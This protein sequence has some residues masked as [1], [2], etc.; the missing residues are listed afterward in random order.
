MQEKFW[1]CVCE[2]V[3]GV[4]SKRGEGKV[5][6]RGERV[7]VGAVRWRECS[8]VVNTVRIN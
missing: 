5:Y 8:A 4:I 2:R 7:D 3:K 1:L 6:A